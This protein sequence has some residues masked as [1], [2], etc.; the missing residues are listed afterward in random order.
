MN[1]APIKRPILRY[2]GGKWRLAPWVIAHFPEHRSYTEVYGGAASVLMQKPRVYAEVYNDLDSE[3]VNVFRVLRDPAKNQQ[4]ERMLRL[5]PFAKDEFRE[6]YEPSDDPLEQARRTIIK[7]FMGFG[8]GAIHATSSSHGMRTRASTW[9]M[10]TGFRSNTSRSG[11]TPAHDWSRYPDQLALFCERL[12]GVV[13]ENRHALEVLATHDRADTLH[14]VDPT[15]LA[16]TRDAGRD[17]RFEMD[18]ED[19]EELAGVL[20]AAVGFVVLSG[21]P[22]DLYE[23]LYSDWCRVERP[24]LADGAK[25]RTEVLWLSPKTAAALAERKRGTQQTLFVGG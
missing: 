2:H 9:K 3:I 1:A 17:Y 19:H 15:Y 23:E 10:P 18:D 11:T 16:A 4:L 25:A 5:T 14:Y 13:I 22:S 6:A 8:S 12:A 20:K 7:S 21:Y 24:H